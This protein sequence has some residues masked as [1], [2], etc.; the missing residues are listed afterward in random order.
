MKVETPAEINEVFD[1]IAYEKTA[2]VLRMIE[3]YVGPDAFRQGVVSYLKRFSYANAAGEDFWNEVAKVTGQAGRSH[4][5][6]LRRS[7]GRTGPLDR[8]EMRRRQDDRGRCDHGT[9]HRRSGRTARGLRRGRCR[10]ASRPRTGQPRCEVI[11]RPKQTV[12]LNGCD[13]ADS[14][15]RFRERDSRGYYFTEYAPKRFAP[16]RGRPKLLARQERLSLLGDEWWMVRGGRHDV[17]VYLDVASAFATDDTS[18][19]RHCLAGRLEVIGDD[20]VSAADRPAYRV[21]DSTALRPAAERAR[22]ARRR[23]RTA[24]RRRCDGRRC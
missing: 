1:G 11:E 10:P 6:Q 13:N 20:L 5:A 17:G 2:A 4:P 24:T 9:L 14:R 12:R 19:G 8:D 16:W 18:A 7:R 23:A 15:R 22:A 3:A 21:V